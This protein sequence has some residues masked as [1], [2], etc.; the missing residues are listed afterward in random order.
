M[1]VEYKGETPGK[2][3]ARDLVWMQHQRLLGARVFKTS[4]HIFLASRIAGDV[5]VL[6][7]MGVPP[8]HIWAVEKD[9]AQYEPLLERREKEGF[10]L[11][12][13]KVESV[14]Y[15]HTNSDLRSVYLDF[16]GNLQGTASTIRR[17]AP[18]LP[19]DSVLTVTLFLGREHDR[20]E[21]REAALLRGVQKSAHHG[22]TLVQSIL[23]SSIT[24]GNLKGSP[25]GTWTF[26]LGHLPSRSKMRFDLHGVKNL[27]PDAVD[28]LWL[29]QVKRAEARSKGATQA[30]ITRHL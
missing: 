25:M 20:P 9:R 26:Y 17:V 8:S 22:A 27:S 11:F 13:Q 24:E 18:C 29:E 16:C 6:R 21:N 1:R 12:P 14:I 30:N 7:D 2:A 3:V 19:A 15:G 23:Y 10:K 28:S 5:Q 4:P